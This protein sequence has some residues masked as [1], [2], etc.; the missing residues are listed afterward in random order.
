M[1]RPSRD[2]VPAPA[3]A[4]GYLL[5]QFRRG[6]E[7]QYD[8]L[9]HLGF[10]DLG[11]FGVISGRA[12]EGGFFVVEHLDSGELVASCVAMRA[13][14]SPRHREAGQLGWLVTD[15]AHTRK[16][17]GTAVAVAA[18]NR[19][20][21]EGHSRPFLGTEDFRTV[22]ISIYLKLGWCPYIYR[23]EMEARW[24]EIFVRLSREAR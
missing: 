11:R 18:T 17:L 5:R 15:P 3:L 6:D 10:E 22:A 24:R 20:A 8:E 1:V 7:A 9:F 13:G 12:L 23:A 16:G 21:A 19:L 4:Q 14:S 2:R